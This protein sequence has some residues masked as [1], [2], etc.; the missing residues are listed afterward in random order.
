MI[1]LND[2]IL[3][4][5]DS[6]ETRKKPS[7]IYSVP[8]RIAR[9]FVAVIMCGALIITGI[10][11][12]VVSFDG[13]RNEDLVIVLDPGHGGF[14][15]GAQNRKLGLYESAINLKI[16]LA[17]RERLEQYGG[18]KVYLTHTGVQNIYGKSSLS[19]RVRVAGEVGADIFISLHINSASNPSAHGVEVFVPVTRH[20]PKYNED[21]TRLAE[22]I[23]EHLTAIGLNSR[24]VKTKKSNGG[25]VYHFS[26]GTSEPGDYYYVVGEP[27]SRLG[28]PGI[29]VEHAFIGT[30]S[31][32]LDSD[33][34]LRSLGFADADGIAAHF[35][36][37]LKT[38]REEESASRQHDVSSVYMP[39]ISS[40]TAE[41]DAEEV[42]GHSEVK[43]L[44]DMIMTLPETPT[45][46]DAN[47][48]NAVR[49]AY[50]A[51]SESE[52]SQLNPSKFQRMCNIVTYYENTIRPVR[53]AVREGSQLSIDR[54]NGR[55]LNAGT[56]EQLSGKI[57]VLSLMVEL[58]IYI[59]PDA[60]DK[61]RREGAISYRV[62]APDGTLLGENDEVPDHSV[63]TILY[64]DTLLD[65][66]SVPINE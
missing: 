63:I 12:A 44:E 33:E 40:E 51:L 22:S 17:C 45:S 29:L 37:R 59:S 54:F 23:I 31:D 39:D 64:E 14:D 36:L 58:D 38:N 47:Q 4:P 16:A 11:A 52:R 48:I 13:E 41:S 53:L 28:I 6:E 21:C 27:I 62:T 32:F 20:E 9:I 19:S 50:Y 10:T 49:A 42:D 61:Y 1:N 55:L 15:S 60:P 57:T 30:D 56:A 25:R 2:K 18:V 43:I 26:D 46:K 7:Q 5:K 3:N 66:L 8:S 35:G 24:G 65:S 34:D